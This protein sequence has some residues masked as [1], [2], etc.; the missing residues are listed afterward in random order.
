MPGAHN[1]RSRRPDTQTEVKLE[2]MLFKG[3][4]IVETHRWG[5]ADD[6]D[7]EDIRS[8]AQREGS[9]SP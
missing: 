9:Q 5:T 1:I 7:V 6:V 4:S 2:T 3:L 8:D